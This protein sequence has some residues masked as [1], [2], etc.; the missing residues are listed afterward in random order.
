MDGM[1]KSLLVAL[2]AILGVAVILHS[3]TTPG[4]GQTAASLPDK[5]QAIAFEKASPEPVA[6]KKA[7][8][9]QQT[10]RTWRVT[11]DE[12][13]YADNTLSQY[14]TISYDTAG[15][16]LKEESFNQKKQPVFRKQYERPVDGRTETMTTFNQLNE[17]QG[18]CLR[19]YDGSGRLVQERLLNARKE[20]QS[21]SEYAWDQDGNPVSWLS[22]GA[23][24]AVVVATTYTAKAGRVSGISL[25]AGDGSP[26]ARFE[27]VWDAQGRM[28]RKSEYD[29]SGRLKAYIEFGWADGRLAREDHRKA[30]G[31]SLRS[32][33]Y[34]YGETPQP[35]RM[36]YLDRQGRLSEYRTFEYKAFDRTETVTVYE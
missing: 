2:P 9:R 10:V 36:D 24:G 26:I 31:S 18:I 35:I 28:V 6:A 32:I 29:Y 17:V 1:N 34:T 3:C 8:V 14:Q 20:L 33:V 13:R 12:T 19:D 22:K 30:D 21:Q 11:K 16:L 15:N 23:E 7:V 27:Q 25:A 4:T 5:S